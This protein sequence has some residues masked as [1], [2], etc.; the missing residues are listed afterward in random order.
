M[1]GLGVL[2]YAVAAAAFAGLAVLAFVSDRRLRQGK[3]LVLAGSAGA[4]WAGLLAATEA[5]QAIPLWLVVLV[6]T[7]RYGSW[8]LFL[9]LLIPT[10]LPRVVLWLVGALLVIWPLF[11]FLLP[12]QERVLIRG[13]LV[14]SLIGLM[15][16]EQIYRNASETEQRDLQFL[17]VGIGGLFAFDLFLF[18]Q[19]E[20]FQGFD[21]DSWHA[22]PIVNTLLV[23]FVIVGARRLPNVRFELF[24]SRNVTFYTTACVAIG[25]YILVT[26]GLGFFIRQVGGQWGEAIRVAFLAGAIAVLLVLI[27]SGNLRRQLRVFLSK[28][29]YRTK[30][31]YRVE[32]LRFIR[33]LSSASGSDVPV[34]AVCSV[35]Q[36]LDS[37]GGVLY[38]QLDGSAAFTPIGSWPASMDGSL[39]AGEIGAASQ[40]VEFMRNR[41]WIVDLHELASDPERYEN[42]EVPAWLAAERRWRLVSPIFLG[43]ALLGFFLLLDPPPPFRLMF[44][45][46]DLLNTAGQ[47]VATLLAQQDADRRV[48]ELSQFETY[49]RLTTFVMHDLK[50]CAAQLSLLVGNAVRHKHNPEFI[51]DAIATIAQTSE[52]MTRLIA[53]LRHRTAAAKTGPVKVL[54]ALDLA[55]ERCRSRKPVPTTEVSAEASPVICADLERFAA[56]LEHVIRN[57]QE[58][59]GATGEVCVSV[60]VGAGR[61]NITVRDTGPGMDAEFIRSRLFRPFDTTKGAGGMGIGAYQAREFARS[62]GGD[63]VVRSSPGGTSFAFELPLGAQDEQSKGASQHSVAPID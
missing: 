19:A 52:R 10:K 44:E 55:L 59:A 22:R 18:S 49:N 60:Q 6:E 40:L 8:L 5:G 41:R 62:V 42:I 45:D 31:D 47:H 48:A 63:V 36:I 43:D 32:W 34:A 20:L 26:A 1:P 57:A 29:F 54:D 2:G 61:V 53:Q 56:A 14:A 51:D 38:R 15:A 28:H 16:L 23:P 25:I 27:A 35:A 21:A 17:M 7:A 37:P 3:A 33:T 9:L 4:V 13:A 11:A 50:N 12:N 58:A 24:V 30:Y 46:R 39:A